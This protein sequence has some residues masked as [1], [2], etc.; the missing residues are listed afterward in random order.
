MRKMTRTPQPD[1][2]RLKADEWNAQWKNL[3]ERNPS[4]QF[5]WYIHDRKSARQWILDDLRQMTKE[6]CSFCDGFPIEVVSLEPVE[7]FRPKHDERFHHLAF[8]W[9]NLYY[10]CDRCQGEKRSQWD[11]ALIAPDEE[12]YAFEDYFE[13]DLPSGK[14]MVNRFA[15]ELQ[16]N[17][18]AITIRIFGLNNGNRPTRRRKTLANW[19]CTNPRVLDDFPYRDF[20]ECGSM[21]AAVQAGSVGSESLLCPAPALDG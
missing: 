21:T 3:R 9:A 7:H 6:H 10:S 16:K 14:I 13:F 18:A 2:L 12:G 8:A 1:I 15:S 4:A 5:T 17:R 20:L 11:D 19:L